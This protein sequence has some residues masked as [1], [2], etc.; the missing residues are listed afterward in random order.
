MSVKAMSGL[1]IGSLLFGLGSL[2][3]AFVPLG[4]YALVFWRLLVSSLIFGAWLLLRGVPRHIPK[5]IILLLMLSGAALALD[6]A[7]WHESIRTIGPGISTLLN[8]LQVFF[9][10]LIGYGYFGE[11]QGFVK[12]FC[13]VLALLGVAL[14][15]SPEF[16][17]NTQALLGFATGIASGFALAVSMTLLKEAQKRHA[18]DLSYAMTWIGIGGVLC[19]APFAWSI[20]AHRLLP[21]TAISVVAVLVYGAIMQCLA[22]GMI[23]YA[24]PRL[25]LTTTGLLL[26]CEP[27][28]A[29]LIDAFWLDKQLHFW[30]CVGVVITLFAIFLGSTQKTPPLKK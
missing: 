16:S 13:L 2:L 4:S 29:L 1:L 11:T 7:L 20:D 30:Q 28:A 23:A 27:I 18:L 15:A 3:V 5:R 21:Q 9:L 8:S 14:I 19:I 24:I 6:L 26:L 12:L 25:S 22:W 17:Q 10:A